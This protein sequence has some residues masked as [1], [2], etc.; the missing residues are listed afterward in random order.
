MAAGRVAPAPPK[1]GMRIRNTAI[2]AREGRV[3]PRPEPDVKAIMR[4]AGA[5]GACLDN[6]SVIQ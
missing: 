6:A 1:S 4:I 5:I 2:F 3:P